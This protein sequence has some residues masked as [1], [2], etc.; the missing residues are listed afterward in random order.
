MKKTIT[1]TTFLLLAIF[2]QATIRTVSNTPSTLAQF[3]TIQA[4]INASI[5]GDTV[6]VHGSPNAYAAFTITNKQLVIIGPGWSPNKNLPFTAQVPGCTID[7]ASCSNTELQGLVFTSTVS[8]NA[9]HPDNLR[10]IRN[11]FIG[12]QLQLLQG[13]IT[14]IG[15]LFEGNIFEG[16][17]FVNASTSSSYQNFLFQNNYFHSTGGASIFSFFNSVNVLFNHNL[18]FG[19]SS[20][21]A[22]CFNSN[23]RFLTLTNNIFVRRDAATNNS[24]STFNNNITFYPAGST[25]PSDPWTLN[26]NINGGGNVSNQDPQMVSE[27]AVNAGTNDPLLDFTIAAGPANNTGSD[28]KDMGLLYDATGSLNWTTSRTSRLPFIFSMN[29]TNPTIPVGGT[30]NVQVEARKNN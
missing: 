15:Y 23:C 21:T 30:L 6:Y 11:D 16:G 7:G 25:P 26:S 17:S 3:N 13:S 12:L 27:A 9:N 1:I 5:S 19:P 2:L 29:I 20:G 8:M 24:S 14:Y 18:W 4:A 10:F 22:I 28:T